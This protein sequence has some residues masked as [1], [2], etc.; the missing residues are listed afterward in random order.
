ME[1]R[2]RR[3]AMHTD[4]PT[5]RT[6]GHTQKNSPSWSVAMALLADASNSALQNG[7]FEQVALAAH[8]IEDVFANS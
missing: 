5:P 8:S 3:Y 7:R 4:N 6:E 1:A 2:S